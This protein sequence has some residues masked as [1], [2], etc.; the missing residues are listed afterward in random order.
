MK[1]GIEKGSFLS[2]IPYLVMSITCPL[3][4]F[5]V[6]WLRKKKIFTTTQVYMNSILG[7]NRT[8]NTKF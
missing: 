1:F 7:I 2:A 3:S 6:D 4:G 8:I 5:F